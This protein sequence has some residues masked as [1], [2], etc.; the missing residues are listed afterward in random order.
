[1]SVQKPVDPPE[2]HEDTAPILTAAEP[3]EK[4]RR[5]WPW[6]VLAIAALLGFLLLRGKHPA[7]EGKATG[8]KSGKPAAPRAIPV[9]AAPAKTGDLG[10]YL[11]GLGTVTALNTVTV[12]SR[13]D[14]QLVSV[15]YHEG[16]LVKAG[17][18]LVEIDPRPFEVQLQQA[19]GQLA[20]DEAT[21]KNAQQDLERYRVLLTQDSISKQQYDQ[22]VAAVNQ[23]QGTIESDR[24]QVASARLNLTYAKVTAPTTGRVGLRLVD[25]GNMVHAADPNGLVVITQLQPIAAVFTIPSDQLP[26]VLAALHAGKML[27]VEAWDRSLTRKIATGTLAAVDNQIDTTTGTVKLKA[28]FDNQ[29]E[30]LFPNLFVNARLLVDTLHGAVLV[31]NA[32][33]QRSP[34]TT[35][36]WVVGGDAVELRNVEVQLTEGEQTALKKGVAPGELVVTDGVDKLQQGTKVTLSSPASASAGARGSAAHGERPPAANGSGGPAAGSLRAP[37]ARGRAKKN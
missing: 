35:F 27:A 29:D 19:Q 20:K 24:S 12:R 11:T 18:V 1:M 13:V 32:A 23:A 5:T 21:L 36:V 15:R 37:S 17:D 34:Q 30:A 4:R 7:S 10:V 22:A 9:V 26:P 31:P 25:V 3:V 28:T 8:G 16:Q 14:G 2:R 6:V 33:I